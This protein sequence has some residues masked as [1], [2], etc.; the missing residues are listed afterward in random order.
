MPMVN[1]YMKRC[2]TPLNQQGNADRNHKCGCV[3]NKKTRDN[4]CWQVCREKGT[5]VHCWWDCQLVQ[6]IWKHY[7]GS[8]KNSKYDAEFPLVGIQ[9]TLEQV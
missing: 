7:E 5:L 2:S 6:P 8:S 3:S 4:K 1:K 9:L